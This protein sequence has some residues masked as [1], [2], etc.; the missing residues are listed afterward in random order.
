MALTGALSV[1]LCSVIGVNNQRLRCLVAELLGAKYTASQMSYDLRRLRLHGI[2]QRFPHSQT[3][4]LTDEGMRVAL[5]YTKVRDRILPPLLEADQPHAP[6]ELR[7]AL[8]TIRRAV[9]DRV[10]DAHLG[11]AA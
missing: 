11:T 10:A 4:V 2:I 1:L 6:P 5:F 8:A 7:A 9:N 3:Y